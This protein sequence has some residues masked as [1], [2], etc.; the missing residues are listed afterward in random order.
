MSR[1]ETILA[2]LGVLLTATSLP[3]SDDFVPMFDGRTLDGWK[4]TGNWVVEEDGVVTLKPRPGEKGWQR[5][6]AYLTTARKYKDFIIDL[7][8]KIE[9]TGNSGVFLRVGDPL[10]QCP[11]G[12]SS[13][14][15]DGHPGVH[16]RCCGAGNGVLLGLLLQLLLPAFFLRFFL[17]FPGGGRRLG[18]RLAT[19]R[20]P[21]LFL[22][23][24]L[25]FLVVSIP[26]A[27]FTD[28]YTERDRRRRQAM[29]A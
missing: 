17:G 3:A 1:N 29:S 9:K 12:G 15:T 26:V 25:L 7:E 23:A 21:L 19:R 27:R 28:W 8:F 20:A 18:P 5:Y 14:Q 11:G 16:E 4:T 10:S 2:I 22:P 13:G 24:A 6:D